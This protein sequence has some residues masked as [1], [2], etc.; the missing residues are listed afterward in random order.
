[1][2]RIL[3]LTV[4]VLLCLGALASCEG[5]QKK[6]GERASVAMLDEI[7]PAL[8][9]AGYDSFK[10][11]GM[12]DTAVFEIELKEKLAEKDMALVGKVTGV[13]TGE[14][15]NPETG[16]WVKQTVIGFD[17][18]VDVATMM[19]YYQTIYSTEL[20]EGK[21]VLTDGGWIVNLTLSSNVIENAPAH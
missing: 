14:Y 4:C 1:M 13:L 16:A 10:R 15:T 12:G 3:L 5:M 6:T 11:Y 8:E 18:S 20:S 2:K 17:T 19:T 9:G 21:A 7:Q